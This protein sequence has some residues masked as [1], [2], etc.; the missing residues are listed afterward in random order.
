MHPIF[1]KI[2]PITIYSYGVMLALAFSVG[3]YLARDRAIKVG[4]D[5]KVIMDL[6]VYILLSSIVGARLLYVLT[7]PDEYREQPLTAIFSRYGF[8][9]YGGLIL[10]IIVG[11]WYLKRKKLPLWQIADVIAPSIPIGQAIGRIGCLLNGCCY[12][13]PTTLPWGVKVPGSDH[14]GL[15][16][17]HPTQIYS[18]VGDLIIFFILSYLW[19]KRKFEGQILLM[20]LV[21]YSI[22][23]FIIEMYRGDNPY[24]FLHLSLSQ[25]LSILIGLGAMTIM[26]VKSKKVRPVQSTFIDN[27]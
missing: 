10:A 13:K 12:G 20:Y 3:I 26:V 9:F 8:V 7:N 5:S 24:I 19:K 22:L 1:F 25:L 16:P 18:S 23:R 17:L 27:L 6:S 4:I 15:T 21:L 2:G 14:L 11:F